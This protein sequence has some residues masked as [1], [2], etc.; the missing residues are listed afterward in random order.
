M[1]L[2]LFCP[3]TWSQT[4]VTF[5]NPGFSSDNPTGNFWQHVSLFMQEA[6]N[7]LNIKLSVRYADR[8]HIL[9]KQLVR[10][11]LSETDSYLI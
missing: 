5:I 7:D 1:L 10:D 6:A 4:K 8:N 2:M 9:M 3:N 11:A